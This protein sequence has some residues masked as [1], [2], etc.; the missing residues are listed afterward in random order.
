[1]LLIFVYGTLKKGYHN[2]HLIA[3]QKFVCEAKTKPVYRLYH[4]GG[5]PCMVEADNNGVSVKGEIY[6]VDE[7]C[8]K[9][10]DKLEG[11]P[12]LYSRETLQIDYP[13][14]VEVYIFRRPV[15]ALKECGDSWPPK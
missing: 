14:K 7:I 11:T 9:R 4:N 15:S 2:H 8:L 13:E 5:F 6:E 1:M 3:R 12:Y 10:L